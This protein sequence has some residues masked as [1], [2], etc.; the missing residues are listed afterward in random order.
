MNNENNKTLANHYPLT[1]VAPQWGSSLASTIVDLEHLRKKELGGPVPPYI[2][3]QLKNIFHMLE[4]L[5]SARIEGNR[6]TLAQLVESVIERKKEPTPNDRIRE[7]LNI[8][9][10]LQF[11]EETITAN[12]PL[13]RAHILEIHKILVKGLP[14]YPDG[15]GSRTPGEFRKLPVTVG[16]FIPPD[17]VSVPG[18][19]DELIQFVNQ[20][21]VPQNDLLITAIAHHRLAWIHPFDNG[22][23]RVIRMFTYALLIKQ[24]FQVG[25]GRILNPTAI[26][27]MD[28][29]KYY[30]M[31]NVAD[32]GKTEHTLAWCEYVLEGLRNEIEKIDKLLNLDYLVQ[33]ILL[34]ALAFSR[35]RQHITEQEYAILRGLVA[36]PRML[37]KSKDVEKATGTA[38]AVTRS[39]LIKKLRDKQKLLIPLREDG[40][41]YT[42]GFSNT[43]LLRGIIHALE[44]NGFIP[45]ALNAKSL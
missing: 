11:I 21:A 19:I 41:K 5:G 16:S 9:A 28:R 38:S 26:F 31:L 17:A 24:G 3:F 4:S 13:Q 44:Q 37:I 22:N 45:Q 35:E 14:V 36:A 43:Y 23:G 15:E 42:I 25:N 27:C 2:F 18:Y 7:I 34:P 39:R 32:S 1:L 29:A 6:T 40:R 30:H 20:K 33:N 12:T 10:A 8:E